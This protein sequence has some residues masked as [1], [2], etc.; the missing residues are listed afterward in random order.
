MRE[1]SD[2]GHLRS[3][4]FVNFV[5]VDFEMH[6]RRFWREILQATGDA[7]I[8]PCPGSE[9]Q[10]RTVQCPVRPLRPVHFWRAE[11]HFMALGKRSLTPSGS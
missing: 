4:D 11:K 2:N 1:I 10:I 7:V 9:D 8:E 6:Y 3:S 5:V